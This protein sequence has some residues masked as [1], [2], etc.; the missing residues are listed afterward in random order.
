MESFV[1]NRWQMTGN[2]GRD[3]AM[4]YM[5]FEL[6]GYVKRLYDFL[7]SA[8]GLL[9]LSPLMALIA[10]CVKFG[11]GGSIFYH[12]PRIGRGGHI[13]QIYKFRT[14]VAAADK[15][16]PQITKSGDARVTRIGRLLRRTKL[17]ELPQLWN[18]LRGDMSLVG[19]RP[20]VPRYVEQY[21]PEQRMILRYK[22]GIT[23]L[24][25]LFFR[26]EESLLAK[27]ANV[28]E[29]YLNYCVPRKLQLNRQYAERANVWSDTLLILRTISC[30]LADPA[31]FLNFNENNS[32]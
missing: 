27:A 20:E 31:R 14:M 17:D 5:S 19:P 15:A 18:V 13:F 1:G 25:S 12:Q 26:D 23:D 22:P 28:E 2:E 8:A 24:A 3:P 7:F 21:T 4:S 11:D 30:T 16:G 9:L 10:I 29:F 6:N 32:R